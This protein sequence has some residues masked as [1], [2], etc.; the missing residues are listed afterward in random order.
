MNTKE[1]F[2]QYSL[3]RLNGEPVT[4]VHQDDIESSLTANSIDSLFDLISFWSGY[5]ESG[6]LEDFNGDI[7]TIDGHQFRIVR[8]IVTATELGQ[9][10]KDDIQ[11]LR[12]EVAA[13]KK[14]FN[15]T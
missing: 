5:S 14:R 2:I 11:R 8:Q 10:D 7:L 1:P 4:L 15:L 9:D 12:D 6:L 3:T 13:F